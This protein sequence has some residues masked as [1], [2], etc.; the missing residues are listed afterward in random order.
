MKACKEEMFKPL[1][2]DKLHFKS[3]DGKLKSTQT[4]GDRMRQFKNLVAAEE[5]QLEALWKEWTEVHQSITDLAQEMLGSTRLEDVLKQPT[6]KLP[7]FV[8]P[9]RKA[10]AEVFEKE[11]KDWEDEIAKMSEAS[12]AS[13]MAGEEVGLEST[14]ILPPAN[15]GI[16]VTLRR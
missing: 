7:D 9:R 8:G 2:Q 11:R 3:N 15:G 5:N 1:G 13:M 4:L 12:M 16:G 10:A 6:G 14:L